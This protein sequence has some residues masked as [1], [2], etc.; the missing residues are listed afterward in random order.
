[1]IMRAVFLCAIRPV[2]LSLWQQVVNLESQGLARDLFFL[3]SPFAAPPP[4]ILWRLAES[5]KM[6]RAASNG[7]TLAGQPASSSIKS[8][9]GEVQ[10]MSAYY[11]L[12]YLY[13]SLNSFNGHSDN[14]FTSEMSKN[15]HQG[16]SSKRNKN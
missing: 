16:W 3:L 6:A 11:P 5:Q 9:L 1:M 8:R 7:S 13:N 15:I 14:L 2:C 12:E 10:K 4:T